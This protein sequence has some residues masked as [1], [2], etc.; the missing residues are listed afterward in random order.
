MGSIATR[1][2]TLD[3]LGVTWLM[4]EVRIGM[5][6]AGDRGHLHEGIVFLHVDVAV[7]LA[8]RRLGLKGLGTDHALDDDL[9]FRRHQQ[10][11]GPERAPR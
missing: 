7:R 11:D 1:R 5:P 10:V 9:G 3:S 6:P 8:E 4:N 2:I